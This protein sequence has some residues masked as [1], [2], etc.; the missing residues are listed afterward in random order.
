MSHGHS[1]ATNPS[2]KITA[3]VGR[4]ADILPLRSDGKMS[5]VTMGDP[6][7]SREHT[8]ALVKNFRAEIDFTCLGRVGGG[9]TE[10]RPAA[11]GGKGGVVRAPGDARPLAQSSA[12]LSIR[13]GD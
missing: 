3:S 13:P 6:Q 4:N 1:S 10:D 8:A 12:E 11:R 9:P 7:Y 2:K 5:P